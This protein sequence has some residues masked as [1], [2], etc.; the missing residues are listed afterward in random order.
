MKT[1]VVLA[2]S[3]CVVR[4]GITLTSPNGGEVWAAGDQVTVTWTFT[5]PTLAAD[6]VVIL[7]R[8]GVDGPG[9]SI[10]FIDDSNAATVTVDDGEATFSVPGWLGDGV[11]YHV[12]VRSESFLKTHASDVSDGPISIIGSGPTKRLTM[13]SPDGGSQWRAGER[14]YVAWDAIGM[15]NVPVEFS[16]MPGII[17]YPAVPGN[18][19]W[20]ILEVAANIGN[21]LDYR[22]Q[23]I[24]DVPFPRT[25]GQALAFD[26]SPLFEIFGASN[27]PTFVIT[28]PNGSETLTGGDE[29]EICWG[30]TAQ[31]DRAA[32]TIL[33]GFV[34]VGGSSAA[35][36]S[37]R[38][39][40]RT[41]FARMVMATAFAYTGSSA[42]LTLLIC[43]GAGTFS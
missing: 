41:P 19:G 27:R 8:D 10:G 12:E 31:D 5:L 35:P 29:V 14:A 17:Q 40:C 4:A 26:E 43:C 24:E 28:T 7:I 39:A 11:D 21:S 23:M 20:A 2:C 37:K 25:P 32:V 34:G 13:R 9:A 38:V 42:P 22:I 33:D 18:D 30:G 6:A 3:C 16:L 1:G 15:D 36:R